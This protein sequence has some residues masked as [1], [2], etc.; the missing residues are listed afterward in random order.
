MRSRWEV[1][2]WEKINQIGEVHLFIRLSDNKYRN[3][4]FSNTCY[5]ALWSNFNEFDA[6]CISSSFTLS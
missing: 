2:P 6:L 3:E 1:R 4:I 5:L